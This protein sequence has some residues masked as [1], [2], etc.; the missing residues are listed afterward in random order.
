MISEILG[1]RIFERFFFK[2]KKIKIEEISPLIKDLDLELVGGLKE[3]KWT[4]HDID[5]VGDHK[6]ILVFVKRLKKNKITNPVHFCSPCRKH[7]HIIT[8]WNGL[9]MLLGG[10]G[11]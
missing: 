6:D 4:I 1:K 2:N 5:I 10:D 3:R 8:L 11:F 9:K 7:S